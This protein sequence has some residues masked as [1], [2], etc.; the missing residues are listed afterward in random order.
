MSLNTKTIEDLSVSHLIDQISRV[1][2]YSTFFGSNDKTP[3]TDGLINVYNPSPS[4]QH[5]K[6]DFQD[7][8]KVQIKGTILP[9][10]KNTNKYSVKL[11][12]LRGYQK[13]GGC[14]FFVIYID[15]ANFS[16]T[17]Y[18]KPLTPFDLEI[19][20]NENKYQKTV[21]LTFFKLPSNYTSINNHFRTFLV[22][23][24]KQVGS[25]LELDVPFKEENN[26]VALFVGKNNFDEYMNMGATLYQ[27]TTDGLY[28][29]Q[30]NVVP[31]TMKSIYTP[32]ITLHDGSILNAVS[33]PLSDANRSILKIEDYLEIIS[34]SE[35]F[36]FNIKLSNFTCLTEVITGISNIESIFNNGMSVNGSQIHFNSYFE[37]SNPKELKKLF[38][39]KEDLIE[40]NKL[41]DLLS[42]DT[43]FN[44][45]MLSDHDKKALFQLLKYSN[46]NSESKWMLFE[47]NSHIYYLLFS[48][49]IQGNL[50]DLNSQIIMFNQNDNKTIKILPSLVPMEQLERVLNFDFDNI[51]SSTNK[52]YEINEDTEEVS[53]YL[54]IYLL[55][56]IKTYDRTSLNN[57]LHLA[58][59]I[60]D[61]IV[62]HSPEN[63]HKI[64][65]Y[66]I[67]KRK[68]PL[69]S[70]EE[71]IIENMLRLSESNLEQI[72]LS[73]LL[74]KNISGSILQLSKEQ[75]EDFERWP[76][77]NLIH[78]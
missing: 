34:D 46:D 3:F 64:N 66:Q 78:E 38:E 58:E 41:L 42:I 23:R 31:N 76:I 33:Y 43:K 60:A 57:F 2:G 5:S 72:C 40:I 13:I 69:N 30:G 45:F 37:S 68:R 61:L 59:K 71:N 12:D 24:N 21:S 25:V 53:S 1:D 35:K 74:E 49:K 16:K 8:I 29:P 54:N 70:M 28:S 10:I 44:Y 7:E 39:F 32:K 63:V 62:R 17:T 75:K 48:D 19:I 50:Y 4:N 18:F 77:S 20:I 47:F 26:L 15:P 14:I 22:N 27:I 51:Y 9:R 73:I 67:L 6:K 65:Y 36:K 56:I 55:E 52:M 11:V